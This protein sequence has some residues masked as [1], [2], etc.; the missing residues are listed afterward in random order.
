M[1][2]LSLVQWIVVGFV[3]GVL[4]GLIFGPSV[5][6]VRPLGDLFVRLLSMIVIPLVFSSLAVGVTGITGVKFGRILGKTFFYYYATAIC[7]I[8]IGLILAIVS[9]IGTG[10]D[11]GGA[12]AAQVSEPPPL[13]S[14]LLGMVP[15]NIVES[16]SKGEML[17][18]IFFALLF[19]AAIGA[20]GEMAEPVKKV[21]EAISET[22]YKLVALV[23]H[24][25]PVGVFCL[26]A[27][28]VGT[29]GAKVLGPL[30]LLVVLVYIGCILQVVLVYAGFLRVFGQVR[31]F[32][33]LWAVREAALVAFTTCSSSGTLP[34]TMRAVESTGVSKAVSG[35]V[36]PVGATVNMDGTAL[37]QAVCAVFLARAFGVP[38]GP[39]Q[40][41]TIGLTAIMASI[42]TAGVPG[43]GM[44]MLTMVLSAIGVPLEGVGIIAGIDRIL[45]MARTSVNVIDD[46]VAA[47]LVAKTE[48]EV[49]KEE[50]LAR[51]ISPPS[52]VSAER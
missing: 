22:M 34:V 17:P 14:V 9:G 47:A 20:A 32:K 4:A 30:A 21:L 43:A 42:G 37:Y 44:I 35:F 11:L 10:V 31:P 15:K 45:D 46:S 41:V 7:S 39:A 27:S 29:Q 33:Y 13:S 49:L 3:L 18:I 2:R 28:T 16:A 23:M 8:V 51:R 19:G 12:Q 26:I 5:N 38:I 48:G 40:L 6:V 25:A 36:L 1:R 24:Y 50:Y 52:G